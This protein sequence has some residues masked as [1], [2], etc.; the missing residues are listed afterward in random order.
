MRRLGLAMLAL[1][2]AVVVGFVVATG[3]PSEAIL[4]KDPECGCCKGYV[5]HLRAAGYGVDAVDSDDIVAVKE[6]LGVPDTM[7]SC[8]TMV[9]G[10]YV[11]EGHVPLAALKRLLSEAPDIAG[12]ALAGMPAGSPGM[13]GPKTGP[14]VIEVISDAVPA[15]TY[16]EY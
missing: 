15:P 7:Y 8:H 9:I 2:V 5:A 10:G 4:Y 1:G 6:R 16:M 11:V 13:E 12:I 14:F 3:G